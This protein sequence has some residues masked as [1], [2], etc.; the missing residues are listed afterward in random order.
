MVR[1]LRRARASPADPDL[2]AGLVLACRFA[3]LVDASVAADRRARRLDPGVRTSVAY[4]YFMRAEYDRAL[5]H[6][7]QEMRWLVLYALPMLGRLDEA[8]DLG[9][10]MLRR[11]PRGHQ[12]LMT[13]AMIAAL[14]GKSDEVDSRVG[15]I[16][17]TTS[18]HDPEGIYFMARALAYAGRRDA[19]LETLERVVGGGFH[20]LAAF[21]RDAWLDPLRGTDAFASLLRRVEEGR[22]AGLDAFRDAGGEPL[23]GV[24]E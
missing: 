10:D 15:E 12:S 4:T 7:D 23:L 20:C 17:S 13:A 19:A 14:E 21:R 6:E 22:R 16:L 2:F 9:R 1:L 24:L 11:R 3:G 18:F 5:E 8:L